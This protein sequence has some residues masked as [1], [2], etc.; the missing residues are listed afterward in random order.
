MSDS[1]SAPATL[2]ALARQA[3]ALGIQ[4]VEAAG[5]PLH[6]FF[7]DQRG[8]MCLLYDERGVDPMQLLLPALRQ[9]APDIARCALV[10]DSRITGNDGRKWD[11]IVVMACERDQDEGLLMAH[12]YVPKGWF[13]KF[14]TEGGQDRVGACRNFI[15][16]AFEESAPQ[17]S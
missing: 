9:H 3:L 16:A 7:L 4:Q 17:A 5:S 11:A 8:T 1:E 12:R 6:P 10:V 15:R 2:E 14:R 13:R